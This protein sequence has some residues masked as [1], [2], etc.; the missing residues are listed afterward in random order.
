MDPSTPF[1]S[2]IPTEDIQLDEGP[3]PMGMSRLRLPL[4]SLFFLWRSS[5]KTPPLL[6]KTRGPVTRILIDRYAFW[7]VMTKSWRQNK[8]LTMTDTLIQH[9]P[10]RIY[11]GVVRHGRTSE[12]GVAGGRMRGGRPSCHLAAGSAAAEG[13]SG[14]TYSIP[15]LTIRSSF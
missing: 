8:Q 5:H 1:Y 6:F 15:P 12:G 11:I 10:P 2:S 3:E 7:C 13:G 4:L 14:S 9:A